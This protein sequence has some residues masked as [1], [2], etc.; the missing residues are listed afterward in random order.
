MPNSTSSNCITA[1][2]HQEI[3]SARSI[4]QL[5]ALGDRIF[6]IV[7]PAVS[8]GADTKN[9]V[10]II[11]GLNDAITIRLIAL[12]ENL[13][14]ISLPIGATYL[15]L[16]SEGR[17]EQTLRTDQDSAIIYIDDL[18]PEKFSDVER[19]AD[20][21]IDALETIGVPRCPGNIMANTPEWCHSITDWE[22]LVD[23]WID[24][25][26]P[27]NM[28]NFGMLQD[29]RALHGDDTLS[30]Q[31]RKYICLAVHR[32]TI[33][34]PNMAGHVVRFPDPF[35]M[36][37]RIRVENSGEYKG[38]IDLKKAGIFAISAGASLLTL[39]ANQIG[40]TTW[41]KLEFLEKRGLF[42]SGDHKIIAESFT[43]LTQL[44][45]KLQLQELAVNAKPTNY[46]SPRLMS[47]TEERQF[48]QALKGVKTFLWIFRNHFLLDLISI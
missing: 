47:G 35:T 7:R 38:M 21:L 26:N 23:Q 41:E 43:F 18:T 20:R 22:K 16:G 19:F 29:L 1:G 30:A 17:G 27:D 4:D 42:T 24:V 3:D 2:I 44:R 48:R 34:F 11:S 32:N 45:L 31:L 37:G 15:V 10:Q 39:E 36:F 9:I 14:G 40:G 6:G 28:L 5:R 12:L 13:E 8:A 33:F 46:V 25:P